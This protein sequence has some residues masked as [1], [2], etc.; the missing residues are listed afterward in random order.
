MATI[1]PRTYQALAIKHGLLAYA[2][3]GLRVNRA[4]TPRAMLNTAAKITGKTF[5]RGQYTEAA[6]ALQAWIDEREGTPTP[7]PA[8]E[9]KD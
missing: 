2:R 6:D 5:K 1:D 9:R 3:S 8:T 7:P 4:Y